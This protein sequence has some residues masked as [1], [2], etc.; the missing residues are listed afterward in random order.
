MMKPYT[1]VIA[2]TVM[3]A[4]LFAAAPAVAGDRG[5]LEPDV[6]PTPLWL[7]M[8]AIPSPALGL[9]AGGARFGLRWQVTPL[10]YSWAINRRLSPWRVLV[11]EPHAR[12][13]GSVELFLSPE[14]Y[15]GEGVTPVLRPG[16]R[17]YVPVVA[18]GEY[19]SLSV[20]SSYQR[21]DGRDGAALELGAYILFGI[22]G[23]QLSHTPGV[24]MPMSTIATV[25]LRYF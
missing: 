23:V 8:Q 24:D 16:V 17:A 6:R 18:R 4:A 3:A 7:A 5:P 11:V 12:Q 19:L 14:V 1:A 9:G 22:L 2:S 25:R 15:F 10:S 13:G 21:L 20:G